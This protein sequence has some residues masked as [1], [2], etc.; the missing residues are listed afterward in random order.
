LTHPSPS[1]SPADS[2]ESDDLPG[3]DNNFIGGVVDK[4]EDIKQID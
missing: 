1:P 3:G 2:S 4:I